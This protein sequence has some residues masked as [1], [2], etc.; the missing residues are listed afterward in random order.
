MID[1]PLH[2]QPVPEALKR[3]I[4]DLMKRHR[5]VEPQ[6]LLAAFAHAT[7]ILYQLGPPTEGDE[8]ELLDLVMENLSQGQQEAIRA[9]SSQRRRQ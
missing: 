1:R 7:G 8:E 6:V 2:E 9:A 5:T 4:Q 3:D